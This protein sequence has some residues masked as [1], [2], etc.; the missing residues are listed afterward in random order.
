MNPYELLG[1]SPHATP[2]EIEAAYLQRL[3][4]CHPD[5]HWA[6]GAEA[7]ARAEQQTRAITA[8]MA[9]LRR[10]W[11]QGPRF[12]APPSSASP[13]SSG[14]GA[15]WQPREQHE[16]WSNFGYAPDA[17]HDWFGNPLDRRVRADHVDCPLCG[18]RYTDPA[19]Y[20]YHL[21]SSHDLGDPEVGIIPEAPISLLGG[22]GR[23]L[24]WIP[25][26]SFWFAVVLVLYWTVVIRFV[27]YFPLRVLLIW[28]G[29]FGYLALLRLALVHRRAR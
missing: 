10:E 1:V 12:T 28:A 17:D 6:D 4:R 13:S 23:S 8:A 26:P 18:Q 20:R 15:E 5:L 14:S 2:D 9:Q 21:A 16:S 27:S 7:V 29:V 24:G 11:A 19:A 3:R 22:R 25:W